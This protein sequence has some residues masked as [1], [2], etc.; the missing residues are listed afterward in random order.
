MTFPS[1]FYVHT[2]AVET[3]NGSGAFGDS[4]STSVTIPCFI[5]DDRKLI[6]GPN[7]EQVVSATKLI[8]YLSNAPL[9]TTDTRVTA[10]GRAA[11]VLDVKRH[12]FGSL[13]LPEFVEVDLT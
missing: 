10:N 2:A 6:V 11:R 8:T 5:E 13:S 4:F 9:F 1:T 12:A 7:G 3:Y